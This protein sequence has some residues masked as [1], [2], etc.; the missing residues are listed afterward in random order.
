MKKAVADAPTSHRS[1]T[2]AKNGMLTWTGIAEGSSQLIAAGCLW[3][4]KPSGERWDKVV[5]FETMFG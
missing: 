1:L 3:K 5:S 2:W 4:G